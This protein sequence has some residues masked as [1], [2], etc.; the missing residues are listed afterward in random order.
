M[1]TPNPLSESDP[2]SSKSSATAGRMRWVAVAAALLCTLLAPIQSMIWNG[3]EAPSWILQLAPLFGDAVASSTSPVDQPS[4]IYF[5][6]GRLLLLSYAGL[7][8]SLW[9]TP[10]DS[11]KALR[12]GFGIALGIAFF[13]DGLA[14]GLSEWFGP[15][16]RGLGFW[17]IEV[18]ALAAALLLGTA[19]GIRCLR[20]NGVRAKRPGRSSDLLLAFAMPLA[21]ICVAAIRY[22]PHGLLIPLAWGIALRPRAV[23]EPAR[24]A[25]I[26]RRIGIAT[27]ASAIGVVALVAVAL[28]YR[29]ID[30]LGLSVQ[31][32]SLD[33][34]TPLRDLRVHI[35]NTGAN[36]MS[37]LLVGPNP[38]WRA[39]P[40][41]VIEHP[42]R[43]LI[44]FDLGLSEEVAEHGEA[45]IPAPVG[46]LM[47]SRGRPGFT[48]DAQMRD[49]GLDPA[50][51]TT[52]IIS[53]L[54]GDHLGVAGS[55]RHARFWAGRDTRH[56]ITGDGSP[57]RGGP[58]PNWSEF[59]FGTNLRPLGPFG[60][61]IDLLGDGSVLVL[62]GGG[63]SPEGVM[64]LV[65]L[66]SG[67]VLLTGD[68][69]VHHDWLESTDVER[70][71]TD[72]QRAATLRNQIRTLRDLG[73]A[74]ILPGHDLRRLGEPRPDL[75]L[76]APE[77]FLSTA[78]PIEVR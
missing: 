42:T 16:L 55:F 38:P 66:P 57:F 18:P 73:D 39:V 30:I 17:K 8:A 26:A 23:S 71:A 76:H 22:M 60:A 47:E 13:G 41:F 11:P 34:A 12:R 67:P 70:I 77:R 45:A 64:A 20:V 65:N 28:P 78:W 1:H 69:V 59:D 52:I 29:P 75:V 43:G 74:L 62:R 21:L 9:W 37:S 19:I 44:V 33:L 68:A 7:L 31:P 48:L 15:A 4:A 50:E 6:F 5:T 27:A 51:V 24:A 46:W 72:P 49:A 35:F 40:A 36:R 61:A 14:Y 25:A 54:H 53:H 32:F 3:T 58:P 2:K 10:I 63:H 56:V